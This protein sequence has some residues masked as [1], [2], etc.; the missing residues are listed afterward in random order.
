VDLFLARKEKLTQALQQQQQQ[1]GGG[2]KGPLQREEEKWKGFDER[3]SGRCPR[4]IAMRWRGRK[5]ASLPPAS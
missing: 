1:P 2:G 5:P 3:P 4:A